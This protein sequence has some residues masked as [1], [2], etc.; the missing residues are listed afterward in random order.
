LGGSSDDQ[1][2]AIQQTIDGGFIVAG[3]SRSNDSDVSG[4]HGGAFYGDCWIVKLAG[5][6]ATGFPSQANNTFSFYPNPVQDELHV[7]FVTPTNDV[8]ISVHD[9]TGRIIAIPII[10]EDAHA[11]LNTS[12]LADG[13]YSLQVFNSKTNEVKIGK[14]VKSE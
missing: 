9:A 10:F 8:S 12:N 14:F 3:G 11:Q 1:A 5:G 6:K 13:L 7:N 4:N 2:N